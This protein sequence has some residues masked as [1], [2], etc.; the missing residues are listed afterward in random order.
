MSFAHEVARFFAEA[1]GVWVALFIAAWF[2]RRM[3]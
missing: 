2:A 3:G 1:L